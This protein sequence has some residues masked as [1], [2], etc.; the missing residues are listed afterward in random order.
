MDQLKQLWGR[1]TWNQR[2]WLVAATLAVVG[3]L[4]A[5]SRW[6]Q[7]R[8]FKPL[9]S[10]LAAE[11]AGALV[12]KLKESGIEYRLGENGSTIL[13][14]SA[15]VAEARLSMAAL[16]LPKSGRIGFELF[17]KANFGASDFAE[18]VNYHR[19]VE[20]ELERSV[21]AVREIEQARIHVTWAK[22]SLY[23]ESRQPAKA[24]VLIKLRAGSK[25]S[26]QNVAAICQ[27]LASAVPELSVEQ[28][29]LVDANGSLLNRP[30]RT[31]ANDDASEAVLEYRKSVERDLQNKIIATLDPLL[32]TEHFRAGVSVDVDIT[33]GDQSE[34][35][36]DPEKQALVT[37]SKTE[38][39]PV[40]PV[41]SGVP[42]TASNLPRPTSTPVSGTSN[43]A[44]KT[45]NSSFQTSRLIKHTKMPQG[46]IKRMSLAVLV[47]HSL[48]WEG[49][50]KILEAPSPEKLKV[51]QSLVSAATGFS[52]DRGDQLVVEALPFESTLTAEP[53]VIAPPSPAVPQIP[54]PKWLQKLIGGKNVLM[55]G[56]I[57]GAVLI[58]L[59][60]AVVFLLMKKGN[61]NAAV[62]AKEATAA[63]EAA[64]A[65][66]A[67]P[68]EL[69]KTPEEIE[70]EI[71]ARILEH[72]ALA[73]KSE[74]EELMKLKFPEINTKKT[75]I[76]TK[77]IVAEA[78]KDPGMMAQVVRSWLND[79]G[80]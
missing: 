53:Q 5:F 57:A 14:A 61:K 52:T 64:A 38:D 25:L 80:R 49:Q 31:S 42:G 76:L 2:I 39:G 73:A 1:L 62:T 8:D 75:E 48:R 46:E 41:D 56:A 55:I 40:L 71:Q 3:G 20:G 67:V 9:F 77:H 27:L 6:N 35:V 58:L 72:T 29:S 12:S 10:N 18:Q 79:G 51:I 45:E 33:S 60:G 78:K 74:A 32:G 28:V 70:H 22:D 69:P 44:R 36:Y 30:R 7:E 50:K 11:D 16:G 66:P 17:D 43:Y 26:P 34:E 19:A 63:L 47:D 24:S 15:S 54:L 37:A 13:V 21:M 23:S 4:T 68:K 59:L 65:E